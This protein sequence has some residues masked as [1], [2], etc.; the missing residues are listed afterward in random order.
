[1]VAINIVGAG[2]DST[3]TKIIAGKE[4]NQPAIPV[5]TSRSSSSIAFSFTPPVN[6]GESPVIGYN[7]L[8]NGGSGSAFST[9]TTITD[10]NDL[11]F[12]KSNNI[13]G[14]ITYEFK[15]VAVN[16]VGDSEASPALA[17]LAA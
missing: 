8:W 10:L 13:L 14:G 15:V 5:M 16:I 12:S 3:A 6:E 2:P 9:L 4:P 11:T 17:I 1:M 7:V